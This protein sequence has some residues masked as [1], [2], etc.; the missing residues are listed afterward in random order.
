M[1]FKTFLLVVV[2]VL[3]ILYLS[4]CNT[5]SAASDGLNNTVQAGVNDGRVIV[6]ALAE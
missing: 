5:I 1:D 3:G 4:G 2:L 6:K